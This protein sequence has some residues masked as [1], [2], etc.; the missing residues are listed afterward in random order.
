M[1]P[2]LALLSLLTDR[3]DFLRQVYVLF[4]PRS[5][6][7]GPAILGNSQAT[8]YPFIVARSGMEG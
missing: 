1:V 3:H 4:N 6:P 5:L 7:S 2:A 8:D